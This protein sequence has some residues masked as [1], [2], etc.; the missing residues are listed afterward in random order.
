M[1]DQSRIGIDLGG[2]KI[3]GIV[4]A[5]GG[6]ITRRIRVPTPKDDYPGVIRVLGE[7]V[8][9]LEAP[10]DT[11]VG[12]GT[13]GA[14]SLMTGLMKN[15]NST[16]LNGRALR[17]DLA[18]YLGREVRI[19]NDAD[20]F[21]LSEASDGSAAGGGTVFGVI[22]GTGV[23]GGICID[24]KLLSGVS[25]I[26]GEWG[27]NPLALHVSR[28]PTDIEPG[29]ACY[30]GRIDCVET[31]LSGPGFERSYREMSGQSRM[32]A[33]IASLVAAGDSTASA[34]MAQYLDLLALALA[35]VINILDPAIIVLG[36]GMSNVQTI[37]ETLPDHLPRYVFSDQINTRVLQAQHGDS[38]G[39]RG[40]AW[41]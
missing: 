18:S 7:L 30:C 29:R 34:V 32:A 39:V 15:C 40:A 19:A 37:Y 4:L 14:I 36:G 9:A 1:S 16:C 27:H 26:C 33:D 20:C 31:W 21:T 24:G 8:L 10:D 25:A 35:T 11:P 13:P 12:I 17:E 23:G 3:E 6:E 5:P 2:T 41:L 22:L 28:N 38:S